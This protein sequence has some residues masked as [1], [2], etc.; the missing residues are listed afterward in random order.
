MKGKILSVSVTDLLITMA[1][2]K[3]ITHTPSIGKTRMN[4]QKLSYLFRAISKVA[5]PN[6][7][8]AC[9]RFSFILLSIRCSIH[10]SDSFG[11]LS[12]NHF[13]LKH[14][15]S[16][17]KF[18]QHSSSMP[19]LLRHQNQKKK[20][21]NKKRERSKTKIEIEEKQNVIS[22]GNEI[23]TNQMIFTFYYL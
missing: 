10:Y 8:P 6:K 5:M 19:I 23:G 14:I 17:F 13:L 21:R 9:E 16:I 22:I 20:K 11:Y 4:L 2:N 7:F 12:R 15:I 18:A 1:W 3:S